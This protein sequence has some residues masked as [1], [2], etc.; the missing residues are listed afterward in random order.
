MKIFQ[1]G[2]NY[3]Q[4][5]FGNRLVYHLQGCNMKCPWCSNPE[6]MKP[7]GVLVVDEE[8]LIDEVCPHHA[9]QEKKLNR[10]VC[11]NCLEH[12]CITKHRTKG[13]YLSYK[14]I[15]TDDLLK[16]SLANRPMFYDGG[17]VTFTGGEA[18]M[19]FKE[20]QEI[21][22]KLREQGIHTA[23]ETNGSHP[24]L[25]ECFPFINQLIIDCKLCNEEKHR[26]VTGISNT[27][28]LD[29]IRKAS[30]MHPCVHIRVPLIG[31]IN[32]SAEEK[33][34]FLDFF[35]SIKG[36]N[37]TFEVLKYHEFG[38][39]KWQQCGWNYTMT[40][41]AKVD[42]ETV[43]EFRKAIVDKGLQYQST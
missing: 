6:G 10:D 39:Q 29:N 17:G 22:I 41:N 11:R 42:D 36:D 4:D 21:L 18:T 38:K 30:Q 26:R 37:L 35:E 13:I 27:L 5:G 3:S 1:K 23:V 32:D 40:E 31:G 19:Q 15:D 34:E 16:E 12:E 8:W 25:S 9:V 20:L 33:K 43:K 28:I 2:F 24:R 7:E 14:D